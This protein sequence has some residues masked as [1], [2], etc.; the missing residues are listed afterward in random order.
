MGLVILTSPPKIWDIG[1]GSLWLLRSCELYVLS[2]KFLII[3]ISL[4]SVWGVSELG[5]GG[6][7]FW[8]PV[9]FISLLHLF[10]YLYYIHLTKSRIDDLSISLVLLILCFLVLLCIYIVRCGFLGGVH[11]FVSKIDWWVFSIILL[12]FIIG[13]CLMFRFWRYVLI[14]RLLVSKV[15]LLFFGGVYLLIYWLLFYLIVFKVNL[16]EYCFINLFFILG[17]LALLYLFVNNSFN[18]LIHLYVFLLILILLYRYDLGWDVCLSLECL[19]VISNMY[20][21]VCLLKL[22]V[23]EN[24]GKLV[25]NSNIGV[26]FNEIFQDII[27]LEYQFYIGVTKLK[28]MVIVLLNGFV[29]VSFI[30]EEIG[31]HFIRFDLVVSFLVFWLWLITFFLVFLDEFIWIKSC[32]VSL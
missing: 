21:K 24:C 5:W 23:Y 12:Y 29:L 15:Y 13:L 10:G 2:G 18:D 14:N 17:F 22:D 7:W 11:V 28:P 26:C 16:A 19:S 8:D 4:G 3:S 30:V 25:F 6:F 1:V 32:D 27:G 20:V 9:E 31:S